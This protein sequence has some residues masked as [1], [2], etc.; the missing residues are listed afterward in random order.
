MAQ[1][2]PTSEGPPRPGY[3]FDTIAPSGMRMS[4]RVI[5][6]DG[7]RGSKVRLVSSPMFRE[8]VWHMA[9]DPVAEGTRI[10]CHVTFRLRL[11][12]S[13]LI[14]PLLLFQG[15]ALRSDL[16]SLKHVLEAEAT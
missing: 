4:Y 8:A 11:L 14:V 10:A 1:V 9:F 6:A 15:R 16:A 7:L 13:W 5:E 3:T 2:I 12:Y